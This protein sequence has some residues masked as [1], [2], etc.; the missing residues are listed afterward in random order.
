MQ[1]VT[2]FTARQVL[3][4]ITSLALVA[5]LAPVGAS[6]VGQLVTIVDK[7]DT[8][9]EVSESEQRL[10]VDSLPGV[11]EQWHLQGDNNDLKP[12]LFDTQFSYKDTVAI[13]SITLV[14]A[15]FHTRSWAD[16]IIY[17]ATARPACD[18][19]NTLP[20]KDV[21]YFR[22]PNNDT[23]HV[24]YPQPLIVKTPFPPGDTKPWVICAAPPSNGAVW[25]VGYRIV[26]SS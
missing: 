23:L 5:L 9:A 12:R 3:T 24:T 2:G 25:A 14:A 13:T 4:L 11:S 21:A 15:A 1:R 20:K 18:Y 7:N 16:F 6:A 26:S 17:A 22:V 8:Q 10:L 19:S